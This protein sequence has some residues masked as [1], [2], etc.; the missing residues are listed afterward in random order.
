VLFV[1]VFTPAPLVVP[2]PFVPFEVP[3]A[4]VEEE[5]V[6]EDEDVVL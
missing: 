4:P 1:F 3:D 5:E 2:L 6:E